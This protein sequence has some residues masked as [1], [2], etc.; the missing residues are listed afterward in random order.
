MDSV[1]GL[2]PEA[3]SYVL[4]QWRAHFEGSLLFFFFFAFVR[5]APLEDPSK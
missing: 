5:K 2:G 3:R 1:H 4:C